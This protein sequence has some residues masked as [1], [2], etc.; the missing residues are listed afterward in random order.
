VADLEKE[1]HPPRRSLRKVQ[2]DRKML[3]EEVDAEDMP[4]IVARW[5][6]TRHENAFEAIVSGSP[7]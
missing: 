2:K 1:L 4:A 7:S 3:K 6:G 5:T